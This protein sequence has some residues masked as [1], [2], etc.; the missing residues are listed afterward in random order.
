MTRFFPA[1]RG[2]WAQ[3]WLWPVWGAVALVLL[4][5]AV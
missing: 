4:F 3:R 1:A 2:L 5:G